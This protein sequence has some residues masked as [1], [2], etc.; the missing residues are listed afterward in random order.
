MGFVRKR[1]KAIY[2]SERRKYHRRDEKKD[3]STSDGTCKK[4]IQ[5]DTQHN[6]FSTLHITPNEVEFTIEVVF[7]CDS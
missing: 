2:A 1:G 3:T 4:Q 7:C 5:R 6:K